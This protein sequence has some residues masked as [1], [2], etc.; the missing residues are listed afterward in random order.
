MRGGCVGDAQQKSVPDFFR[1][2]QQNPF[3][4]RAPLYFAFRALKTH[5]A[6]SDFSAQGF[7]NMSA[8]DSQLG[9]CKHVDQKNSSRPKC[10]GHNPAL[11]G[12]RWRMATGRYL[13]NGVFGALTPAVWHREW[14]LRS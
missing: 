7:S 3:A 5:I 2:A 6:R 9:W 1:G 4:D 12:R 13:P 11:S 10:R 8:R 14:A